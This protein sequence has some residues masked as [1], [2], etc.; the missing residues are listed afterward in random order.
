MISRLI[1]ILILLAAAFADVYLNRHI[2]ILYRL[3]LNLFTQFTSHHSIYDTFFF[4][5]KDL[6][7]IKTHVPEN[8]QVKSKAGDK[9]FMHY[10][11]LQ[12]DH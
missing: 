1:S 8:C 6:Q 11:G 7:I 5:V 9:L 2:C 10:T 3:F 4:L 12:I